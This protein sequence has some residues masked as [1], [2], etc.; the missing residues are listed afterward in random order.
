MAA[1]KKRP[2]CL[3]LPAHSV[4]CAGSSLLHMLVYPPARHRV[5]LHHLLALNSPSLRLRCLSLDL[6]SGSN[7]FV[8]ELCVFIPVSVLKGYLPCILH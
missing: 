6:L 7:A 1:L 5:L 3:S 4:A 8:F 2:V